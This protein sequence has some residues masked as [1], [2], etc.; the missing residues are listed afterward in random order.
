MPLEPDIILPGQ[1]GPLSSPR[2][3]LQGARL[4]MLAVLQDAIEC[5]C[6]PP[7]EHDQAAR[8]LFEET[9]AWVKSTDHATFSFESICDAL[10]IDADYLRRRL[11][12]QG[13]PVQGGRR[14]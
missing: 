1:L 12:Q 9:R 10:D 14:P 4:L 5:Y 8:I 7:R 11:R 3:P 2:R 13:A 6:R